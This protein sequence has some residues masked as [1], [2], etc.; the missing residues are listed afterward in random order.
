MGVRGA[1]PV[2]VSVVVEAVVGD[3]PPAVPAVIAARSPADA[4]ARRAAVHDLVVSWSVVLVCAMTYLDVPSGVVVH[5]G[6]TVSLVE[7][8]AVTVLAWPAPVPAVIVTMRPTQRLVVGQAVVMSWGVV[9][10]PLVAALAVVAGVA[11]P[12]PVRAVILTGSPANLLVVHAL[13]ASWSVVVVP[14][15]AVPVSLVAVPASSLPV[16][17]S[18]V[19]VPPSPVALPLSPMVATPSSLMVAVPSSPVPVPARTALPPSAR[20][21]EHTS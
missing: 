1:G 4:S 20:S 15:L 14:P 9:V 16:P 12:A 11:S 6:E 5:A 21:E 3:W 17:A 8:L 10:V 13:V 7:A 2:G 18:P 19:P